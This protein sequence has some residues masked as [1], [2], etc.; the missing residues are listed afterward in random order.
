MAW[1]VEI[2]SDGQRS[3]PGT[4]DASDVLGRQNSDHPQTW[5]EDA[6]ITTVSTRMAL[7][8][9]YSYHATVSFLQCPQSMRTR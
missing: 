2:V 1:V 7:M 6:D 8:K 3:F 9:G 5:L 4:F